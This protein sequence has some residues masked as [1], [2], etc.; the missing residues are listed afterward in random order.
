MRNPKDDKQELTETL[1]Q[2]SLI[3]ARL[4]GKVDVIAEQTKGGGQH[5]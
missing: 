4:E 3:L 2:I 1:Y 5:A